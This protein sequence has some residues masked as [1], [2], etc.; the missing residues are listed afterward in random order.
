[1]EKKK[2][3]VRF[4]FTAQFEALND[5]HA[6]RDATERLETGIHEVKRLSL[7]VVAVLPIVETPAPVAATPV[8]IPGPVSEQWGIDK[9]VAS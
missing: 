7:E 6:L 5:A 1:M 2:Y 4:S 3:V 8:I 9:P